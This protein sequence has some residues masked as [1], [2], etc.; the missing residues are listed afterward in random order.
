MRKCEILGVRSK[1]GD[2]MRLWIIAA[3]LLAAV[4]AQAGEPSDSTFERITK[5]DRFAF[6]GIGYGRITSQGEKDYKV[7]L[8]RPSAI[9]DFERLLSVG[10]PQAKAYALVGIRALNPSRFQELSPSLQD[11]KEKVV[12]QR[13]CL[14]YTESLGTLVK[15]IEAVDYSQEK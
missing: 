13:G 12:T 9:A 15:S 14:G 11:S 10:N 2:R 7:I 5:V 4:I 8:S 3:V 1:V 6:G